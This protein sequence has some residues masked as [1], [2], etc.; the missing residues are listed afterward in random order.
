MESKLFPY[1]TLFIILTPILIILILFFYF[2]LNN[3]FNR[4]DFF[5]FFIISLSYYVNQIF[6]LNYLIG[7]MKTKRNLFILIVSLLFI[8]IVYVLIPF[9]ELLIVATGILIVNITSYYLNMIVINKAMNQ[10][11]NN[12][13]QLVNQINL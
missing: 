3:Y 7:K 13:K 2:Y 8:L 1:V 12:N 11:Y 5:L 10:F 6:D 9:D 4:F